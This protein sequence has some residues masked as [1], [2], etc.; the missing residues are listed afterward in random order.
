R[1]MTALNAELAK[2]PNW[3]S[4]TK[5]KAELPEAEEWKDKTGKLPFLIR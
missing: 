4:I 2:L 5:R 1:H 3:K